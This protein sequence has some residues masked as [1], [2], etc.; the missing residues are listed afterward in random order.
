[1]SHALSTLDRSLTVPPYR[2]IFVPLADGTRL[3]AR[4]WL[5]ESAAPAPLVLEWIPYRQSDNTATGDAMMHGFFAAHGIAAMRIDLRGSGNSDG[6]LR[7]EYLAQEQDDAVE[8]IAWIARQA[9]CNGN[10]GMIGISWGGFAALQIAARRPPALKAIITCCSTDDRYSD[11][12]HY[13]GGALLTDGLQWGSGLF[14]QLGRPLDPAHVGE[15]WREGWL[16][17]L[18]GMEPPL[19]HWLAHGDRDAFWR[20]GSVCEDYQAIE[21]AVYAVGGWTDGYCDAILRLMHHLDAPRKGLI[22]P[23]THVYPTWGLPGPA[24]DFLGE[25]LRFWRQWLQGENTGIMDEPMLRLWQGEGLRADP[26]GMTLGGQWLSAPG[27]PASHA[28]QDFYLDDNRLITQPSAPAAP[29][30]IDTPMHCGMTGG[31]WCPLDGGGGA[32]EFQADQRSD[33]GLSQCFDTPRLTAPLTLC[34]KAALEVAVAFESPSALLVLRLNEV[35]ADG[36]SARVTFG[37]HRLTRPAGVAPGE[38][39]RV[40]LPFKGV[41]YRFSPGCRLRLALSTAYWPMVWAEPGQG[42]VRLWPDGAVLQLPG[43]GDAI[44]L[45]DP[46]FGAPRS[47]PP[48]PHE[49]VSPEVTRRQVEWDVGAGIHRVVMDA[50]RQH[51]RIGELCFGSEGHEVYTIGA[52][53]ESAR[54]ETHRV[55]RYTRPG[56]DIRLECDTSLAWQAGGLVLTSRY[57][58]GTSKNLTRV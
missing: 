24:I 55:Q 15:R 51:T 44:T 14:T 2:Q 21:C 4:L 6:L 49:V 11:D 17:R 53:A 9:W 1:M 13:M 7:D 48:H 12:V 42:P 54:M 52:L 3:A 56:W 30:M 32:P 29:L 23:W 5:P 36:H 40:R 19:A 45:D 38:P 50:Q 37:V 16:S 31:E 20:H 25:C 22:G 46:A 26:R 18:A 35:S 43:P 33:D 28:R 10:V 8:V 34:G 27:W 39:F 57:Q 47:A 41:A 58:A